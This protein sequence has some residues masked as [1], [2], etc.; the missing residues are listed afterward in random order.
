MKNK[1]QAVKIVWRG[2]HAP[3]GVVFFHEDPEAV[4]WADAGVSAQPLFISCN[5]LPKHVLAGVRFGGENQNTDSVVVGYASAIR[6]RDSEGRAGCEQT[7][8]R[9]ELLAAIKAMR[10]QDGNL[11]IRSDSD[12][13]VRI[14]TGPLQGEREMHNK[15]DADLW[16]AFVTELRLKD[17]RQPNFVLDQNDTR[18]K[19]TLTGRSPPLWTKEETM[20]QTHWRLPL[21]NI[22]Q[23]RRH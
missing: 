19:S 10:V 16:V 13:V 9:A 3:R 15:G 2:H 17:T 14:A 20:L 8:N 6:I 4:V 11:V 12:Y 22:T 23:L 21:R 1:H 18:Q 7:N 5:T